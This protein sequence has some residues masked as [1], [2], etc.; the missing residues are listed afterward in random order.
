MGL[1]YKSVERSSFKDMFNI[2]KEEG[3]YIIGLAGNPN[4]GKST[5]FNSLTGLHQHTGNWPGKTVVNA[6]GEFS[7]K[8]KN[9][10]LIDL[11]G[12]YS[13]FSSSVEETVARDF[14]C[15]ANHDAV[16]VV[17]DATCLERNLLLLFQVMEI[18]DDIVFCINLIDEAKKKNISIDRKAIEKELGVPVVFTSARDN[19]GL[20]EL[21]DRVYDVICGKWKNKKK[22]LEF[23]EDIE[24]KVQSIK[25]LVEKADTGLNSRWLSLR[26]L[27]SDD[28]IF[29][30]MKQYINDETF[31]KIIDLRDKIN[32]PNKAE[33]RE[34][35]MEESY[36]LS[37]KIKLKYVKEDDLKLLRDKK[38]DDVITSKIFGIPLMMLLLACVLWITVTGAN[39]P[40]EILSNFLFGIEAKITDLFVYLN[41]PDWLHGSLVLGLYRTLAWVV[42]VML[43]PMA[44]FFPMF[45][46]LEDLG[47]LPRVAFNMDHMFKKACAHGKQ[48][49]TMCMGFGC[50]AAGVVGCR[51][52][53]SPRER[54]IAIVTNNFVPCN[55]RF[56]TL[57]AIATIFFS[58]TVLSKGS[59]FPAITVTLF[60]ILGIMITLACSYLL[61]KTLLKGVTSSFTLELPPYRVPKIGRVL[62]TSLIDRTIFVLKRAVLFAAPAGL[63]TWICANVYIG[64]LSI[65]QHISQFL[66]PFAKVIGLDGVILMA[67][68]FGLPAN[69]I[70]L[71]ILIMSYLSTGHMIEFDSLES[72]AKVLTNNGWT[73]LTAFNTM[74]FCLLHWPCSTTLWTIK[75]ETGSIKWTVIAFLLPTIIG[76]ALCF[77]TTTLYRLIF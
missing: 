3:Q 16:I 65:I 12:T 61:S 31:S 4:T 44:I 51:I 24:L 52:I 17:A 59:I 28:S 70:V 56:P 58:G 13:I 34:M 14:I 60:I 73:A 69:E 33:F 57:I 7:H 68:I 50:N 41:A 6:R 66:D 47:Y 74:L 1:T 5:V 37:E 76:I 29:S 67:F 75:Q 40:S 32:S 30:S 22:T 45:T 72:L 49:L 19:F 9:Y 38:I 43:P 21:K 77:V 36:K 26:L 62:Y 42:S 54:I 48:C 63:I 15:Y 18:T 2:E 25:S 11:P 64:D 46:L 10:S 39:I 53:E 35:I 27:D 71:P 8:D 55:G 23:S 20:D